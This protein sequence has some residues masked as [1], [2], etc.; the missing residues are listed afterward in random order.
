M[1]VDD[2][3][4]EM[5]MKTVLRYS[6]MLALLVSGVCQAD[7]AGLCK[8]MC[9]EE[10]RV[11]RNAAVILDDHPAGSLMKIRENDR[12]ARSFVDG[13]VK[14]NQPVGPEVRNAQDRRM[15][16]T[17]TCDDQFMTCTKACAPKPAMS[18]VLVKPAR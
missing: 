3:T 7:D 18:D 13:S 4:R 6:V 11:C 17:R 14:T 16:R 12:M 1:S 5:L 10:K 2:R 15:T 8:P 9:A